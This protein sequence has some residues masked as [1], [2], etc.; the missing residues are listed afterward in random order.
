MSPSPDTRESLILR[1]PTLSDAAAWQ[2]FVAVYEPLV[3][4]FAQRRG[5]QDADARELA[6]NVL[7]AVARSVSDWQPDRRRGRFRA[8]LF[9]I[10]RNQLI[11]LVAR[12]RP[13]QGSGRSEEWQVLNQLQA[14]EAT[15]AAAEL[16]YR[17]ELFRTAAAEIREDFR[18]TT[19]QAFW[20]CSVLQ[21][22]VQEVADELGIS[23]GAVYIAR[24]RVLQRLKTQVQQWENDDDN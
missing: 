22:S 21:R 17:R 23:V 8:W 3:L 15:L 11:N 10:A 5:L 20:Q 4:R 12:K 18:T 16:D 19:W 14:P 1:L 9:R 2:Q 7:V 13:D 6:Q 24:S